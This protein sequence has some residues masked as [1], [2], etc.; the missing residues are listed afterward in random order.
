VQELAWL[1]PDN[2]KFPPTSEAWREPNGLLAAGGDLSAERLLAAYRR[3]IFPWY[4][5]GQPPLWW[6]PDPRS[7]LIPERLHISR[8]L[9]RD[10]R[11][12][13]FRITA[14]TAFR[15][16]MLACAA[17]RDSEGG[18]WITSDMVNAY[19]VL[20]RRSIAHSIEA[21]DD[22]GHLAGGLYGLAIGQAFFGESMFSLKAN[23][24]KTALVALTAQLRQWSFKLIDCQ[25]ENEHLVSLGA[26]RVTR[27]HFESLLH[28]ATSEHRP[29]SL[30]TDAFAAGNG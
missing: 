3:G 11:R 26:E 17:P 8:S 13:R 20:H 12:R 27:N 16:V 5:Q 2:L 14:D 19:E 1:D 28:E 15:Q 30:W 18:T 24:S 6:S 21:W 7:I 23:A 25:V 4:Q 10:V 22:R 29:D 9:A